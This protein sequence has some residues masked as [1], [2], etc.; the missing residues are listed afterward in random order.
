M[1][2][3]GDEQHSPLIPA[4]PGVVGY[5]RSFDKG[6]NSAGIV[7]FS[8]G[9]DGMAGFSQVPWRSGVYGWNSEA[10]DVAFGVYGRSNSQQG[11]GVAGSNDG[12]RDR[13]GRRR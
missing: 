5:G 8:D 2:S 4:Q 7:G 9:N 3:V 13:F 10:K 11:I 6:L 1:H 12:G